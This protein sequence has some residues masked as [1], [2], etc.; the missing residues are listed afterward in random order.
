MTIDNSGT[1]PIWGANHQA[2]VRVIP[3]IRWCHVE[4]P[5]AGGT[6]QV[7][8]D[9]VEEEIASLSLVQKARLTTWLVNQRSR[10]A[11]SPEVTREV[12]DYTRKRPSLPTDQ[13]AHRLLRYL[14][15]QSATVG[16]Q[17][18]LQLGSDTA[19]KTRAK[20]KSAATDVTKLAV[21]ALRHSDAAA[22]RSESTTFYEIEFFLGF[23]RDRG[24]LSLEI[25][26]FKKLWP[27]YSAPIHVAT[28]SVDGYS[29]IA[30]QV[31]NLDSSQA[32]VAMWFDDRMKDVYDNGIR[33]AIEEAG[34]SSLR[35]D[36]KPDV[37]KIDDEIIAEIR[38]SR[39]VVAD[40]THGDDGA[41]GGVYFEAGFAFG[42]DIPVIYTC[43]EDIVDKLH[44]DTR[45]YAH[46]LWS[47]ENTDQLRAK[48]R[49]RILA[50]MGEGP[51]VSAGRSWV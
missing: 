24:W 34:Y 49:N 35:I 7:S 17:V 26:F 5:R 27:N 12:V 6:Y 19:K 38:R 10:G 46:I 51:N 41:R 1:C 28:V 40:F 22:A 3:S 9:V 31:T 48:L 45:Q 20:V 21:R 23:L 25:P 42:L 14:A 33:P 43:L 30:D 36:E 8:Q 18:H 32:F 29:R 2:N 50:R 15:E 39:F 44:F 4:S 47:K 11:E 13:R 16:D 37:D